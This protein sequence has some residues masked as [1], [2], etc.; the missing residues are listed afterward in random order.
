M[1]DL[2]FVFRMPNCLL[3]HIG[4]VAPFVVL[5]SDMFQ[6]GKLLLYTNRVS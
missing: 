2:V 1:I 4:I 5:M 6:E 3:D